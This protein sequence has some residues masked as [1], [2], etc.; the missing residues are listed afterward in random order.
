MVEDRLEGDRMSSMA[1]FSVDDGPDSLRLCP[2]G[3]AVL[4]QLE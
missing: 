4:Q 2:K 3:I 1:M